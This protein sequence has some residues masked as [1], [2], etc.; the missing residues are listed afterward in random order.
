MPF[1]ALAPGPG[2]QAPVRP[3]AA[4]LRTLRPLCLAQPLVCGG[5]AHP[6]HR[7]QW[8]EPRPREGGELTDTIATEGLSKP[9]VGPWGR[10]QQGPPPSSAAQP[11]P[12][13]FLGSLVEGGWAGSA[14]G[15]AAPAQQEAR[16]SGRP[17]EAAQEM[18]P[19]HSVTPGDLGLQTLAGLRGS[20]ADI[21]THS[22]LPLHRRP[23]ASASPA[24]ATRSSQAARET[25]FEAVPH[26][27]DFEAAG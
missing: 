6:L 8:A 5:Q 21:S 11:R 18:V 12:V 14:P 17:R 19:T 23:P 24:T 1:L 22:P 4:A 13:T 3:P 26:E 15:Q 10:P 9:R 16:D 25:Q 27:M 20:R 7:G 2:S